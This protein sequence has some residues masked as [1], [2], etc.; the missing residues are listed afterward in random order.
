MV[1]HRPEANVGH[2]SCYSCVLRQP[3]IQGQGT[4]PVSRLAGKHLMTMRRKRQ[5]ITNGLVPAAPALNQRNRKHLPLEPQPHPPLLLH[6]SCPFSGPLTE[7]PDQVAAKETVTR[8]SSNMAGVSS[9]QSSHH[10]SS[11]ASPATQRPY[12]RRRRPRATPPH[13]HLHPGAAPHPHPGSIRDYGPRQTDPQTASA[14]TA[15][16]PFKAVHCP[17]LTSPAPRQMPPGPSPD[18][19]TKDS[20]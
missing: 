3:P 2:R 14:H 13:R 12:S 5:R 1:L 8:Q 6:R 9:R 18:R 15:V 4:L 16:S 19:S 10:Y 17:S 11:S 7:F 20:L